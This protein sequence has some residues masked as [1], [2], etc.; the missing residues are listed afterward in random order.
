MPFISAS[1][2]IV[3]SD[4]RSTLT[5]DCSDPTK[6]NFW[7]DICTGIDNNE[8]GSLKSTID[9]HANEEH[10]TYYNGSHI[11]TAIYDD[12]CVGSDGGMCYEETVLYRLLSGIH[13]STTISIAKH[14]YPPSKKKNR[15]SYEPNPSIAVQ[16]FSDHPEYV[17]NLHF[18]YVFLLRALKKA[19][20]F[21]STFNYNTGNST[22]DM[23][24]EM[25]VNRLTER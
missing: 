9:L 15:T 14:Y 4:K 23:L 20:P 12:N 17:R 7:V 3:T 21:L 19:T 11:W 16:A 13:S 18:T 5:E 2:P 10:N 22:D 25:L 1:D 8:E 6:A 24:T